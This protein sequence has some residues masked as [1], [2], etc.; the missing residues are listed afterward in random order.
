MKHIISFVLVLTMVLGLFS[1][2]NKGGNDKTYTGIYGG[3]ETK[4]VIKG[5][6]AIL[7]TEYSEELSF[8]GDK[9]VKATNIGVMTGIITSTD[10]G[11]I[12]ISFGVKGATATMQIKLSGNGAEAYKARILEQLNELE[13]GPFKNAQLT[14]INGR[15]LNMAYGDEMWETMG[16]GNDR[17]VILVIDEEN[18]TFTEVKDEE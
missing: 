3:E 9:K 15:T 12:T 10:N 7:S 18:G 6:K 13:D 17:V 11:A 5:N 4:L 16:P 8:D 1:C 2:T 14:L